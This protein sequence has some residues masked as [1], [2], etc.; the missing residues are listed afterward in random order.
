MVSLIEVP[1]G[2][3]RREGAHETPCRRSHHRRPHVSAGELATLSQS[4]VLADVKIFGKNFFDLFD[5]VSS[6]VLLPIGGMAIAVVGGWMLSR[7]DIHG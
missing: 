6:N 4:H 5:F 7:K 2:M 3:D 1:V